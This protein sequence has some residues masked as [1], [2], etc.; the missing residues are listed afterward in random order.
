MTSEMDGAKNR[1]PASDIGRRDSARSRGTAAASRPPQTSERSGRP[2]VHL[3]PVSCCPRWRL[4]TSKRSDW[5][6]ARARTHTHARWAAA[7][8]AAPSGRPGRAGPPRTLL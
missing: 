4:A 5:N 7:G 3:E 8:A 1:I 2:F 6:D